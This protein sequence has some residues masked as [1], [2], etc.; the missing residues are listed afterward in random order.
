MWKCCIHS[1]ELPE[2]ALSMSESSSRLGNSATPNSGLGCRLFPTQQD[3]GLSGSA[4]SESECQVGRRDP[5]G[6]WNH[7]LR[8]QAQAQLWELSMGHLI[9]PALPD[10]HCPLRGG[11]GEGKQHTNSRRHLYLAS[12]LAPRDHHPGPGECS[13]A[14]SC[15]V[16]MGSYISAPHSVLEVPGSLPPLPIPKGLLGAQGIKTLCPRRGSCEQR[17]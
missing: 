7:C 8:V 2:D 4:I 9:P 16:A 10:R 13:P 15:G 5:E 6:P 3:F 14:E 11:G 17:V 1:P 12:V